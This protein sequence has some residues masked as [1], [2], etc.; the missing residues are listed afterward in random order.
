MSVDHEGRCS[1]AVVLL[2]LASMGSWA[3][4]LILAMVSILISLGG[5]RQDKQEHCRCGYDLTG[6]TSGTCPECGERI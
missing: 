2:I 5:R 4:G 1:E 3:L 6:N